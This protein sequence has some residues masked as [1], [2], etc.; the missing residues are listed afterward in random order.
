V[1]YLARTVPPGH[2]GCASQGLRRGATFCG[3]W[4]AHSGLRPS[5]RCA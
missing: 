3:P 1:F 4:P 5:R 2:G